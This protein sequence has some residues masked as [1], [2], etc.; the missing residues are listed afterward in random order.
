MK[1]WLLSLEIVVVF[2]LRIILTEAAIIN[3]AKSNIIKILLVNT[4]SPIV[5]TSCGIAGTIYFLVK[6][7]A[8][9]EGI[10]KMIA[11]LILTNPFLK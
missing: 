5:N 1:D 7:T 9:I 4:K 2:D 8:T 6:K 3:I 10:P 11:V